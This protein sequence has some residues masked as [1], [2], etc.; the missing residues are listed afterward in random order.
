MKIKNQILVL[1]LLGLLFICPYLKSIQADDTQSVEI[2]NPQVQPNTI[3]VGD[4]FAINATIINNSNNTINVQNGCGGAFSVTFDNHAT[5]E[6]NKIC[7]W[8]AIQIILKPGENITA[9]NLSSNLIYKATA[10]GTANA[11]VTF[12]YIVGN[13]TGSNVS[14][15]GNATSVSKSFT[16]DI[17]NETSPK[18]TMSFYPLEQFKSGIA[19]KD[20]VCKQ[21]LQLVIKAEDGSPA[22]VKPSDG[23]TLV[24]RGWANPL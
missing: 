9:S 22:C 23:I 5:T 2:L 10:S 12:S 8:M 15:G 7:N 1:T 13:Q 16:F 21:D 19:P 6:V 4:T 20:V 24:Q 3:K 17:S 11:T 14:F 18:P